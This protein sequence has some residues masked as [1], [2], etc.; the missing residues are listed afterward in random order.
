MRLA[1]ASSGR[2]PA[3]HQGEA[4][5]GNQ[6]VVKGL[7]PSVGEN[8]AHFFHRVAAPSLGVHQHDNAEHRGALWADGRIVQE[9]VL[10]DQ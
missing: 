2:L 7:E 4:L 9:H 3:N 10:P 6:H 5:V 8:A 1:W